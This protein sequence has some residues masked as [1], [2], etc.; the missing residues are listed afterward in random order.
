MITVYEYINYS[1][2]I[3]LFHLRKIGLL[4]KMNIPRKVIVSREEIPGLMRHDKWRR[5]RGV[6]RQ[7]NRGG[8]AY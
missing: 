8:G 6:I 5:I 1:Q 2:S 3:I 7:I 4:R